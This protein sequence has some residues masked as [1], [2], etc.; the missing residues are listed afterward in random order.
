MNL[1]PEFGLYYEE[2]VN[3]RQIKAD[4]SQIRKKTKRLSFT[5]LEKLQTELPFPRGKYHRVEGNFYRK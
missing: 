1:N 4:G 2:I 3:C 5:S